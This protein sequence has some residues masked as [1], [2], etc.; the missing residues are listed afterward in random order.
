M[1]DEQDFP[2]LFSKKGEWLGF[3]AD[4]LAALSPQRRELYDALANAVVG[5]LQPREAA[6]KDAQ[7]RVASIVAEIREVEAAKPKPLTYHQLWQQHFGSPR[8][9]HG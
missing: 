5:V 6:R 2:P 3:D 1:S 4:T 7:E 9:A 8:N